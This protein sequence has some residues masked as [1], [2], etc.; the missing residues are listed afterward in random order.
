MNWLEQTS[1]SNIIANAMR[2]TTRSDRI[3]KRARRSRPQLTAPSEVKP[4]VALPSCCVLACACL[5]NC[6][7]RITKQVARL[8][9]GGLLCGAGC[10]PPAGTPG[11]LQL[12]LQILPLLACPGLLGGKLLADQSV[13][14]L[15]LL[16]A[17]LVIVDQTEAT[18]VGSRRGTRRSRVSDANSGSQRGT[19]REVATRFEAIAREGERTPN[20]PPPTN[21]PRPR[22]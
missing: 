7:K 4:A 11:R 21:F 18:A 19:T 3:R 8:G 14:G 6:I 10:L 13:P 15:E 1:A 9:G 22:I 16:H 12:P 2:S 17:F 20:P 5:R